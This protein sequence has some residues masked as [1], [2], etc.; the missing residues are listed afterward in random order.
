MKYKGTFTLIIALLLVLTP[1]LAVSAEYTL[2][3]DANTEE[4]LA[5]YRIYYRDDPDA[6][7]TPLAELTTTDSASADH[8]DPAAAFPEYRVSGLSDGV[9]YYFVITAFDSDGF[10]SGYSN[11]VHSQAPRIVTAPTVTYVDA[12]S[13]VTSPAT[14]CPRT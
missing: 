12:A 14:S 3:W 1:V 9:V 13:A 10:E 8:I 7:Y 6:E 2:Q 5:G 11:E 4:N